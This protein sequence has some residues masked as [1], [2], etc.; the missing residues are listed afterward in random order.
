MLFAQVQ[1]GAGRIASRY[2]IMKIL[3][4]LAITAAAALVLLFVSVSDAAN[5]DVVSYWAAARLLV[6]NQNPYDVAAIEILEK[7][8]GSTS[9]VLIARNLPPFLGLILPLGFLPFQYA[10]VVWMLVLVVCLVTSIHLLKQNGDNHLLGYLFAPALVCIMAGQSGLILLLGVS[11]FLQFH[12]RKP[13][14]AG[15]GL[16]VVL[17]KPHLFVLFGFGAAVWVV[18]HRRYQ[19]LQGFVIASAISQ[20]SL[21]WHPDLWGA[22]ATMMPTIGIQNEF[23]PTLGGGLRLLTGS[24]AMQVAPLV[25][26]GAWTVWYVARHWRRWSW[27][28]HGLSVLLVSVAVAPYAWTSDEA[29]LLPAIFAGLRQSKAM[30]WWLLLNGVAMLLVISGVTMGSGAYLWTPMAWLIWYNVLLRPCS[31]IASEDFLNGGAHMWQR[32]LRV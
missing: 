23:V 19:I 12:E 2:E 26:G 6:N 7:S 15:A 20:L 10:A 25:F 16:A 21:L 1:Y 4:F 11:L 18:A 27:Q 9:P 32:L 30:H 14:L 31:G 13:Q 17:F 5:R 29:V 24:A 3:G 28:E 22:Y 8:V